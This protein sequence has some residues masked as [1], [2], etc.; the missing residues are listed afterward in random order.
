M[1]RDKME[2]YLFERAMFQDKPVLG[3]CRGIQ[4]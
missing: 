3:I 2:A 1:E 4:L